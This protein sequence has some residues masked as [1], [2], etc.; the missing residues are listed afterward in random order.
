MQEKY[1]VVVIGSGLGGLITGALLSH[2]GYKTLVVEKMSRIGGRWS[3]EEYEGFR[4]TTGTITMH[5][6]DTEIEAIFKEI[7]ADFE[8]IDVPRLFYR[9]KGKDYE[10]PPKGAFGIWLDIVNRLEEDRIKLTGGLAKA[11]AK[12]KI[13]SAW[14]HGAREPEK[15]AGRT[16]RQWLLQYTDNEL[17]HSLFDCLTCIFGG[18]SYEQPATTLFTYMVASKGLREMVIPPRG[19]IANA[20]NLA[21]VI[22]ANG[23]VWVNCPAKR[24]V[25]RGKEAKGVVVQRDG[26]E[27]EVACQVV[28]SDVGPKATVELVGE[29]NYD[30]EYLRTMRLR[31]T[32][33]PAI[34]CFITSD[35]PLWP[36]SGESATLQI[37]GARRLISIVPFSNI[38]PEYAP[39]GQYL[40]FALGMPQTVYVHMDVEYERQQLLLDLKENL[41]LFEKHGRVLKWVFKNFDDEVPFL[42]TWGNEGMPC[43]TPV[44]NLYNIGDGVATAPGV[45][46]MIG[47]SESA[48][49]V[50]GIVR[51]RLKLG[52]A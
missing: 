27:V 42:R 6:K 37:V 29:E 48:R 31:L 45:G 19:H 20:E 5:Y 47:A 16:F 9:I 26:G 28:V 38:S 36:E 17:T 32:P 51:K 25:V 46:G 35:R 11:V 12:E 34:M 30:E 14:K 10:M 33:L 43:E 22:G 4:L 7:G 2:S 50:V 40:T 52:Q 49:T 15:E 39:P 3:T 1:D 23:D 18:H 8:Y 44:R 21:K 24:I 13:L 41:P